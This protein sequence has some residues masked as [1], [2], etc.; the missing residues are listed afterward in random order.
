[1]GNVFDRDPLKKPEPDA[2]AIEGN[3]VARDER[4]VAGAQIEVPRAGALPF[5]FEKVKV[6]IKLVPV[7]RGGIG[8]HRELIQARRRSETNL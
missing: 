4:L 3:P 5:V 2:F 1:M 7:K 8:D 6:E